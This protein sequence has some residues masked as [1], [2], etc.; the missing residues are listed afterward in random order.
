MIKHCTAF[1]GDPCRVRWVPLSVILGLEKSDDGTQISL[2][3]DGLVAGPRT[4]DRSG[5]THPL[6]PL[7]LK[8]LSPSHLLFSSPLLHH[9]FACPPSFLGLYWCPLGGTICTPAL[10]FKGAYL[11]IIH[12]YDITHVPLLNLY[13]INISCIFVVQIITE[14]APCS[15]NRK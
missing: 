10:R 13:N 12:F 8:F 5:P 15:C 6:T 9:L 4:T 3:I 14:Y 1:G 2:E 7:E 11:S